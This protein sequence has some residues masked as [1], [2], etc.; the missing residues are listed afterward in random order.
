MVHSIMVVGRHCGGLVEVALRVILT[1]M[2]L[3]T[4]PEGGVGGMAG[5]I[6]TVVVIGTGV[7]TAQTEIVVGVI[8]ALVA[9]FHLEWVSTFLMHSMF[10]LSTINTTPVDLRLCQS[11]QLSLLISVASKT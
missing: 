2:T 5:M 3:I 10:L 4:L 1:M 11:E 7:M 6:P 9:V 8:V